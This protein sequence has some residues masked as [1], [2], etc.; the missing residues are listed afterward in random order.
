MP[1]P[2]P[3]FRVGEPIRHD[4]LAVFPLFAESSSG[5]EYVLSDEAIQAGSVAVEEVSEAGSVP[6][7]AVENK[8]DVRVLFLEGEELVG[9]K[10]NRILNTSVLVAAHSKTKIP[11][12]CVEAGRW[13]YKSRRFGSGGTHSPSRLRYHLKASVSRSLKAER[14]YRSDQGEVWAEVARQQEALGAFSRT[15]AMADTFEAHRKR[16][17]EFRE[18][19]RYADGAIGVA[20]AVGDQVV[21][22]DLFDKPST[23]EK[24]WSRLLSGF[25]LDALELGEHERQAEAGDV[26][27]LLR[28]LSDLPWQAADP[29]GEGEEYRAD[30]PSGDVASA[31]AFEGVVVHSSVV[32]QS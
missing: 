9:A 4:G 28:G 14:S 7:L 27:R 13:G 1:V 32:C 6:D 3:E 22:C 23:C 11:V 2:F 15:S 20:V 31:L 16:L 24:V 19:L 8:G 17:D 30:S 10:Q 21:A 18:K 5:V 25:M 29:I 26:D 12:S